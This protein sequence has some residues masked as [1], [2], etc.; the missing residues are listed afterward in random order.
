MDPTDM[1]LVGG[2]GATVGGIIVG[3]VRLLGA[4]SINALDKTL[5][6]LAATIEELGRDIRVLRETDIAQAKDIG[7]LQQA[8][9]GLEKRVDGQ[10]AYYRE[11]FEEH[12]RLVHDRMTQATHAM[13][14]AAENASKGKRTK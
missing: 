11:Q 3:L 12:R 9:Q 8:F 2:G 13:I 7:S 1:V 14:D 4:R 10:G 5:E 6:R